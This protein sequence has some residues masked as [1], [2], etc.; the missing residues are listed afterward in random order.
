MEMVTKLAFGQW[1]TLRTCHTR[2]TCNKLQ[3]LPRL[4][5]IRGNCGK[6]WRLW[7]LLQ[8]WG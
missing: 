5:A 6:L 1:D 7:Q 8:L 3:H 4:A 2:K